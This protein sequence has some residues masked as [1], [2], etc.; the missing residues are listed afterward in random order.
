MEI[1]CILSLIKKNP[2]EL[3]EKINTKKKQKQKQPC[4]Q[5]KTKQKKPKK[6]KTH[7][8]TPPQKNRHCLKIVWILYQNNKK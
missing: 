3:I 7:T 5:K 1:T 6:Q 2:T 8:K 4:N